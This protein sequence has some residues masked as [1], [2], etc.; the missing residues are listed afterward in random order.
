MPEEFREIVLDT[1]TTGIEIAD[2]HRIVEIGAVELV[3]R[4]PTGQSFH[5]YLN[6]ERMMPPDAFAIHGLSDEFLADKPRF[7]DV[8]D[9]FLAF[10]GQAPLVAHNA[11][12]DF[13]FINHELSRAGRPPLD[14]DRVV[15]TLAMAKARFPGSPSSLDALSRKF[16]IDTSRR[17]LHGALLDSQILAEVYLELLGGRQPG[18]DLRDAS[19]AGQA[20][21]GAGRARPRPA[22]LPPRITAE[23]MAAHRAFVA[24]M[25][26]KSLWS[27]EAED[28]D[29]TLP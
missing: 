5:R 15:D 24:R 14:P 8:A 4:L 23:E 17:T 7:P 25:G 29:L 20:T 22:P 10:L 3:N 21:P 19:A 26:E 11:A 27:R 13:R 28:P 9:D 2:D 1:E 18:F 6:P 12:F 16:G